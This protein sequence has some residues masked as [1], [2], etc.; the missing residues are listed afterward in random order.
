MKYT[1]GLIILL[2]FLICPLLSAQEPSTDKKNPTPMTTNTVEGEYDGLETTHYY[3]FMANKGTVE[4]IL[5]AETQRYSKLVD[6]E[7]LDETGRSLLLVGV[8]A[9]E[10]LQ[11]ESKTVTLI[12]KQRVI[13][14]VFLR[15][16][17][18]IK[19][20]TYKVQVGG[21]VEFEAVASPGMNTTPPAMGGGTAP[22]MQQNTPTAQQ[23]TPA[24]MMGGSPSATP[25]KDVRSCLPQTG[26]LVITTASGESFEIDLKNVANA[27]VK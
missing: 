15:E 20:L 27:T 11:T 2:S 5:S 18:D 3:S 25:G 21:P 17:T 13:L 14:R 9:K 7:L 10:E 8:V 26:T 16:D 1:I 23:N 19:H 4:V 22:A 6:A 24:E 12:R